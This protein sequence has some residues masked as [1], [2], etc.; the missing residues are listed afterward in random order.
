M[1]IFQ[2][3]MRLYN[4][5]SQRLYLNRSERLQFK[6]QTERE[7]GET[8]LLCLL[9]YYTGCRISE[10]LNIRWEHIQWQEGII[11]I[12][13]LKKR[14]KH[15]IRELIIPPELVE[16]LRQHYQENPDQPPLNHDRTTGWRRVTDVMHKAGIYDAHATARGLR[17]SFGFWC[18]FNA[19]PITLCQRWMG[20]SHIQITAIYYNAVGKDEIELASRLW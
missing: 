6:Q 9:L 4:N 1:E 11:A 20:H 5:R 17:H 8:R 10:V 12:R 3:S 13:S 16:L 7:D 14:N 18:A 2:T 19:I 15:H